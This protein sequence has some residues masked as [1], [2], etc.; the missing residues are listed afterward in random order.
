MSRDRIAAIIVRRRG[1]PEFRKKLLA[2]Y[3]NRCAISDCDS[4]DALEAA[5]IHP[6]WGEATNHVTNGVLLRADL[7]TLFDLGKISVNA[8][9]HS[10]IVSDDLKTT[11]YGPLHGKKL[12]LPSDPAHQ[13]NFQV[14]RE[15]R[16]A[17]KL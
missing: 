16:A 8:D 9:T 13:P 6:Y 4:T 3:R 10:V 17:A 12:N 5:H 11:V 15:H 1:Q 2:A 14:I 7:H